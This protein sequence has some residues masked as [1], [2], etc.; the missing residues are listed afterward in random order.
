[1]SDDILKSYVEDFKVTY[2][3]EEYEDS[4]LFEYFCNQCIISKQYPREFSF[5]NV[6]VDG[7][8]DIGI[9]AIAIIVNGNI[10]QTTAEI[11]SLIKINGFLSVQFIFI[12]S[13]ESSKFKGDQVGTFIFGVKSFFDGKHSMP[14]N[15]YIKN[16]R[17]LKDYLYGKSLYF[18]SKPTLETYFVTAGVWKDPAQI[19][20][21]ADRELL[22]IAGK[23]I[24]ESIQHV[25]CDAERLKQYYRD[26]K[27]KSLK[28]LPFSNYISL[29]EMRG[30]RQSYIGCV[31]VKE[32]LG[33]IADQD[34]NLQKGLFYDNVRD[35]QGKNRVNNEIQQTVRDGVRQTSLP[36]LNNGVTIIAKKIEPIGS[37]FKLT[38]LQIVN[39][40]QTSH[41][42]FANSSSIG[43]LTQIVVKLIEPEDAEISS[44][45][46][47]A[48]N[49]QTEVKVEAF[50]SLSPFHKDLEEYYKAKEGVVQDAIYYERRSKQYDGVPSI[51]PLQVVTLSSQIKAYIACELREPQS[52]HR[53]FGELLESYRDRMFREGD[54]LDRYYLSSLILN[55]VER[56]LKRKSQFASYKFMKYQ[57][58]MLIYIE[59]LTIKD[60]YKIGY[61]EILDSYFKELS[62]FKKVY[63]EVTS[64]I[65]SAKAKSSLS[66]A[67]ASRSRDFTSLLLGEKR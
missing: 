54:Q 11:D 66:Y 23:N 33:L 26:I 64:A 47:R 2:G 10:I 39:G 14:E 41:V 28:E 7:R 49:S 67:D 19:K 34:G 42:L 65:V 32:Y 44:S 17:K 48:T 3:L 5:E 9:D 55:R 46:I 27:L 35:F 43:E 57:L 51:N 20:G 24:F 31:L 4:E 6:S 12:Q 63:D 59:L 58:V 30:V 16:M 13:K 52:T 38:D 15:E 21:R 61:N 18:Q 25:F 50:E 29:P 8:D 53:Y 56:I 40:C 62:E 22:E 1:M 45:V 37:K 60:R 36:I